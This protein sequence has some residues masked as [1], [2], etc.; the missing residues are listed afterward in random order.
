[1]P[2]TKKSQK[3]TR[4]RRIGTAVS[5]KACAALTGLTFRAVQAA[6]DAGCPAIKQNGRVDCDALIKWLA[7]HPQVLEGAGL[8]VN[9]DVEQALKIRADRMLREHKLAVLRGQ[10]V[11]ASDMQKAGAELG[12]A[13][14]KIVEQ[15]HLA[16]PTVVGVSVADAEARLKDI[17]QEIL[18]QLHGLDKTLSKATKQNGET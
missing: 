18:G 10:Y 7:N 15:I 4:A 13:V 16:A 2:A 12:M 17:E 11:L 6:K 3:H 8:Q 5:M 9:S 14:R 1:M